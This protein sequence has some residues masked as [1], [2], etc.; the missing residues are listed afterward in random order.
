MPLSFLLSLIS[1]RKNIALCLGNSRE[2]LF[3]QLS[4]RRTEEEKKVCLYR[5]HSE[6][7]PSVAFLPEICKG[8]NDCICE[9]S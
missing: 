5:G 7:L 6:R 1:H 9:S 2:Q 8:V 4:I 3:E